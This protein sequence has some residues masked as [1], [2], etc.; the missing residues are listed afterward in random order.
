METP[1][2]TSP[3]E[4][5][6]WSKHEQFKRVGCLKHSLLSCTNFVSTICSGSRRGRYTGGKVFLFNFEITTFFFILT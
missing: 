2:Y 1:N 6:L 4:T 3:T 5:L